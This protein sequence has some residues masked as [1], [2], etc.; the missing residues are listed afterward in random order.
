M[1]LFLF[2]LVW[3]GLGHY[4]KK[5]QHRIKSVTWFTARTDR[6]ENKGKNKIKCLSEVFSH[7]VP[8]EQLH[9]SPVLILL[10]LWTPPHLLH[11]V[12]FSVGGKKHCL[13]HQSATSHRCPG[14]FRSGSCKGH[15]IW[16][17]SFSYL[18]N[19]SVTP[20]GPLKSIT[21]CFCSHFSAFS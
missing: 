9:C 19:R 14:G 5:Q 21:S 17:T 16:F 2:S 6:W 10:S 15:S 13:T 4:K 18:S 12:L 7:P 11:L 20:R 1:V 8:P 3:F